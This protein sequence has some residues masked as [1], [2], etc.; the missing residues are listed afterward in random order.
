MKRLELIEAVRNLFD[1]GYMGEMLHHARRARIDMA[2]KEF[3]TRLFL[4]SGYGELS[5]PQME[6]LTRDDTR[7]LVVDL[8]EPQHYK[9]G[10]IAGAVSHP[11]D[12]F[13]KTALME[14]DYNGFRNQAVILVC[15]TGH[16]SR[17]AADILAELDFEHVYSLKR[18][19]RRFNRWHILKS[20]HEK[21]DRP[22]CRICREL[23]AASD[24]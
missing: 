24:E 23:F 20:T 18:G 9:Q 15:N 22:I 1:F 21:S 7:A 19:M 17:V 14:G 13:L 10:H 12:D 3:F 11:F 5:P 16:K 8:R 2:P 4:G 6:T